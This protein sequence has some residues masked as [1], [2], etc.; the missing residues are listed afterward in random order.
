MVVVLVVMRGTVPP[1]TPTCSSHGKTDVSGGYYEQWLSEVIEVA[2]RGTVPP[3]TPTYKSHTSI[4]RNQRRSEECWLCRCSLT[5]VVVVVLPFCYPAP[6]NPYPTLLPLP[7]L[8][9]FSRSCTS[10]SPCAS[11]LSA[12]TH[13][14][15][16]FPLHLICTMTGPLSSPFPPLPSPHPP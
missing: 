10:C 12:Q 2:M 3:S 8:S 5:V 13:S 15:H 14:P 4:G 9:P 1:S 16:S 7:L 6:T 11:H